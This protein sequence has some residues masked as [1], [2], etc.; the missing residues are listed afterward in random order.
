M[1]L[2]LNGTVNGTVKTAAFFL[3]SFAI[4]LILAVLLKLNVPAV[5]VFVMGV[6]GLLMTM[7]A[8]KNYSIEN[9]R[10]IGQKGYFYRKKA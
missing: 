6:A 1:I 3:V 5:A 4:L 7:I 2:F 10:R 9:S 8:A